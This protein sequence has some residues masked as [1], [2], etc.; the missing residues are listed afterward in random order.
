MYCTERQEALNA[1][2][3]GALLVQAPFGFRE[4]VRAASRCCAV[5]IMARVVVGAVVVLGCVVL[6]HAVIVF[7]SRRR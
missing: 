3:F 7:E 2:V 1:Q 4:L 6:H 5:I